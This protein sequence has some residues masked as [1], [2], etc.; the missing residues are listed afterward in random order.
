MTQWYIFYTP[1]AGTVEGKKT[2]GL[3]Y[4]TEFFFNIYIDWHLS[5]AFHRFAS[6][7][8]YKK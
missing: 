3:E 6:W 2:P 4:T 8:H 1:N 7:V 5:A